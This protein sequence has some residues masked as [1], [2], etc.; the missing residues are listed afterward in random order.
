MPSALDRIEFAPPAPVRSVRAFGLALIAHSLLIIALTWGVNWKR[1]DTSASF[2]AEIWS[3]LPQ[4][5]A[6]RM[7]TPLPAVTAPVEAPPQ[8]IRPLP[9]A[10][11]VTPQAVDIA[12]A[13]DK[14]R[15]LLLQQK[16]QDA[17]RALQ[18]KNK[19]IEEKKQLQ[20]KKD[21]EAIREKE[22][23]LKTKEDLAK[24]KKADDAQKAVAQ[25]QDAKEK[26]SAVALADQRREN[27]ARM[28]GGTGP[29]DAKGAAA[30]S[31][32]PSAGYGSKV[33]AKVLPNVVFADDITG[34]P[35]AVIS[36]TSAP[37]GTVLSKRL[38]KSSGNTAWDEAVL[39][40]IDKTGS[41]PRDTDGK[42]PSPME[43]GFQPQK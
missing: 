15:K 7:G 28:M 5:A 39:R 13:Q 20:A 1:S 9:P 14:K 18:L 33:A 38:V 10:A 29:E 4:E 21:Q 40:A 19:V 35:K 24:R 16:E 31:S 42:V 25:N 32:G 36:V 37:D 8:P 26:A 23:E 11:Q 43:I 3:S 17:E 27:L 41:M 30:K 22:H 12:L 6:P 2:E 34:N